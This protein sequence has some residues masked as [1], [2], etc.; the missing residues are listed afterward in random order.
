M[1]P[2]L[3]N[4]GQFP[5]RTFSILCALGT[6]VSMVL[7]QKNFILKGISAS[8]EQISSLLIIVFIGAL[9]GGR[10]GYIILHIEQFAP[11]STSAFELFKIWQGGG[12]TLGA[13]IGGGIVL[14]LYCL[15][16]GADFMEYTDSFV[17]PVTTVQ[18]FASIGNFM[19]GEA[20]GEPTN[21]SFGVIFPHGPASVEFPGIAVH[22]TMLYE[23]VI[24]S[25]I[26]MILYKLN[27]IEFK[28][29]LLSSSFILLNSIQLLG[30]SSLTIHHIQINGFKVVPA[31]ALLSLTIA[32]VLIISLELYKKRE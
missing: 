4:F 28:P 8:K 20:Y 9:S 31:F 30:L 27:T 2:V 6:L 29:G 12:E 16:H 24:F 10:I 3:I 17:L 14:Y 1:Y 19:N 7:L 25:I 32:S 18:V 22:P 21:S 11:S 23:V 13:I 5:I 26:G 15:W